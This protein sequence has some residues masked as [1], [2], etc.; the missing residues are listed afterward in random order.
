MENYNQQVRKALFK[1]MENCQCRGLNLHK[2]ASQYTNILYKA[3]DG[4]DIYEKFYSQYLVYV[5]YLDA[6]KLNLYKQKECVA[7]DTEIGF[8]EQLNE[9]SDHLDLLTEVSADPDFLVKLIE[10]CYQF[11]N[12]NGLGKVNIVKSLDAVENE[13]LEEHFPMHRQDLDTYDIKITLQQILKNIQN[14]TKHQENALEIDFKEAIM[15]SIAGF[16]RNLV[17]NDYDNAVD[18]L[19]EIA[20]SD[21]SSCKTLSE[22]GI[23]DAYVLDHIDLYENYS[24]RDILWELMDNPVF[25]TDTIWTIANVYV[26]GEYEGMEIQKEEIDEDK[27]KSIMKKLTIES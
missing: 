2:A 5:M 10:S 7:S 9:I 22:K 16:I 13:W 1:I 25:L 8:L 6:Y 23:S 19:I 12:I 14:Q 21:Y 18:L 26:Y 17:K 3:L 4:K 24:K 27:G 11:Y 20:V 15:V